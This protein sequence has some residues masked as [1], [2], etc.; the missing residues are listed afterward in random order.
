MKQV[1]VG[2][3]VTADPVLLAELR[4]VV[5]RSVD[6]LELAPES[7][8]LPGSA[9][10]PGERGRL[11]GPGANEPSSGPRAAAAREV[12]AG[13]A[14]AGGKSVVAHGLCYSPGT[15]GSEARR[16]SWLRQIAD[17]RSRLDF[18]WYSDHL[19]FMEV[20]G[21]T[22]TL[23][24]PLPHWL[25]AEETIVANLRR[26]HEAAGVRVAFENWASLFSL[27]DPRHDGAFF[28]RLC[29]RAPAFLLLDLHNVLVTALAHGIDPDEYLNAMPFEHVLCIHLAG[30]RDSE[31]DWSPSGRVYRLD[32]HD[33]PV[34]E[35]E[36]RAFERILPR[37]AQLEGVVVERL[38]LG[39]VATESADATAEREQ[40]RARI[41]QWDAELRRVRQILERTGSTTSAS[42]A[43]PGTVA[44]PRR[45]AT[46]EGSA[47]D[48]AQLQRA[49][50]VLLADPEPVEAWERSC[51]ARALR[52]SDPSWIDDAENHC[53]WTE[54]VT[55]AIQG[56]DPDAFA[57]TALLAQKIRFRRLLTADPTLEARFE[58]DPESVGGPLRDYLHRVP[59]RALFPSEEWRA[60]QQFVAQCDLR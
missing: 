2:I 30:G 59:P 25:S 45:A 19:G 13:Y 27:S 34:P 3:N 60:Y 39:L 38:D 29:E 57:V 16:R 26:L 35:W 52:P 55:T 14:R 44:K 56:I 10:D 6:F 47:E 12:L 5:E 51:A 20:A 42:D 58:Q 43:K 18:G 33:A 37:C 50:P 22:P 36:W 9:E 24:L 54:P 28:R 7:Y 15:I 32:S 49:L 4:S 1:R 48:L 17:D 31:P 40:L 23:P 46:A 53:P 11:L 41:D 8:W 21:W